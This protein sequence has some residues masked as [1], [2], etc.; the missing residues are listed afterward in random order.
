MAAIA[1]VTSTSSTSQAPPP[2]WKPASV[3]PRQLPPLPARA[4]IPVSSAQC[5]K[6]LNALLKHVEKVQQ[7]RGEG[8][9]LGEQEEK[10]FLVVGLKQAPKRETHKPVR[11]CV[12]DSCTGLKLCTGTSTEFELTLL[13][14]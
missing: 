10:V 5:E 2:L 11:M 9:L 8:E 6:A 3:A 4:D 7:K 14:T 12:P 13:S 1:T